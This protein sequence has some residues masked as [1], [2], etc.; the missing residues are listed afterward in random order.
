M[1]GIIWEKSDSSLD[2]H[3]A[4]YTLVFEILVRSD[5]NQ[6]RYNLNKVRSDIRC[7]FKQGINIIR[8]KPEQ[9]YTNKLNII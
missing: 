2:V 5:V 9:M 4:R 1:L 3:Q 6:A 7:T 8:Q